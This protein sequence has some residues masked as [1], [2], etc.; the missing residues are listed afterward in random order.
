MCLV[1]VIRGKFLLEWCKLDE[2][3]LPSES[4]S[5]NELQKYFCYNKFLIKQ[6]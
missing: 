1:E 2:N 6:D 5:K 4:I 3:K